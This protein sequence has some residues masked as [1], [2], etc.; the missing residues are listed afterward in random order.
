MWRKFE[1]QISEA[2]GV[3]E[4]PFVT[5]SWLEN[6]TTASL[7]IHPLSNTTA[8]PCRPWE[9]PAHVLSDA[10]VDLGVNYEWPIITMDE[11]RK[12]VRPP[13]IKPQY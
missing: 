9:A 11:S 2:C 1:S 8:L 5:I 10:G 3:E 6:L 4:I 13:V 12:Q 7:I